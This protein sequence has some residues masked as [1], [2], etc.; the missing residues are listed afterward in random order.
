VGYT[1]LAEQLATD[2]L[3][4]AMAEFE[5]RASDLIAGGGGRLVKLIGDEVMFVAAD[6][7]AGCTILLDLLEALAADDVLPQ[8]RGGLAAGEVLARDGDYYGPVVNLASRVV[9]IASPNA[10][11]V[12]EVV[13]ERLA[14]GGSFE[15]D[16]VDSGPLK[17]VTDPVPLFSARRP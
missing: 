10:A 2:E 9:K 15:F 17:G 14:P 12:T 16:A 11:L 3:A 4:A 8:L 13:K 7:A 1:A 6:A 5:G